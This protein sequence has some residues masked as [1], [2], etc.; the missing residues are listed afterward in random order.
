MPQHFMLLFKKEVELCRCNLRLKHFTSS[1]FIFKSSCFSVWVCD[2]A[3]TVVVFLRCNVSLIRASGDKRFAC[4]M[5][6]EFCRCK[7]TL[8]HFINRCFISKCCS[9]LRDYKM[10]LL[11][12][13]STRD[14]CYL[15]NKDNF[16]IICF[17]V[18]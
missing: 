12:L 6:A 2:G 1:Y 18:N 7:L 5:E 8:V 13:F 14:N 16:N 17:W 15:L 9:S 11:P 4:A 3:L 10:V